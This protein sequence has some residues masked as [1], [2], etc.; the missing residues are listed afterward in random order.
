[1]LPDDNN[2]YN[3]NGVID[4][5]RIYN[6]ALS[7][8]DVSDLLSDPLVTDINDFSLKD[9]GIKI[10]P[11]PAGKMITI[12]I[13]D[14]Q[15]WTSINLHNLFG[16]EINANIELDPSHGKKQS[17]YL[18]LSK[19]PEGVYIIQFQSSKRKITERLIIA[20]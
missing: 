18:D 2:A 19:Y 12:S 13:E 17:F 9:S 16:Q 1:M 14:L 11:N 20:R 5:I 4:E 10:F 3:F 8:D 7:P 15:N 6:Y